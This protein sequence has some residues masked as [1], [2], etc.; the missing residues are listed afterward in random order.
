MNVG[1][2]KNKVRNQAA[3][4]TQLQLNKEMYK[5]E[6]NDLKVRC[7]EAEE[8]LRQAEANL[9]AKDKDIKKYQ[10]TIEALQICKQ[11]AEEQTNTYFQALLKS[12][13]EKRELE[14]RLDYWK[15]AYTKISFELEEAKKP[16]FKKL[17]KC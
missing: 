17:L 16:W 15:E 10:E 11:N 7:E 8:M 4:I 1:R 9:E 6:S 12:R 13:E 14:S 2:L 5:G 3:T